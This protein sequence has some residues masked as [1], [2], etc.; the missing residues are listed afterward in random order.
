MGLFLNGTPTQQVTPTFASELDNGNSGAAFTIAWGAGAKQKI[1]LNADCTLTMTPPTG[2]TDL[3]VRIIQDVVGGR[4][5]I[6]PASI[7][8]LGGALPT[9]STSPG[10]SDIIDLFWNGTD[11]FAEPNLKFATLNPNGIL[12]ASGILWLDGSQGITLAAGRVSRWADQ[13]P[14]GNDAVQGTALQRP[15]VGVLD[16]RPAVSF[17][18]TTGM[19]MA[20]AF[21]AGAKTVYTVWQMTALPGAGNFFG[22]LSLNTAGGLITEAIN[23][24]IGGYTN[25]SIVADNPGFTVS[26]GYSPALNLAKHI[27]G[28]SYNGGLIALPASYAARYDDVA[29]AIIASGAIGRVATDLSSVGCRLSS[30]N[31]V[32]NGFVGA[33]AEVIVANAVMTVSQDAAIRAYLDAKYP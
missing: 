9:L 15:V 24:N 19:S 8:W 14:S 16:G 18:G 4:S 12:G 17:D 31:A 29:Q 13:S 28:F 3:Q 27:S 33:I 10:A 25:I 30:L 5:A 26:S 20:L 21:P 22:P 11:Y 32:S 6:W 7:K 23:A 2:V 1:T